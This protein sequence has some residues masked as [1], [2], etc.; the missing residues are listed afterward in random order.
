ME[1]I[2]EWADE[3]P[4]KDFLF[5]HPGTHVTILADPLGSQ[6]PLCS[7]DVTILTQDLYQTIPFF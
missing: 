1:E 5:S 2:K 6:I 4:D 3:E 7:S